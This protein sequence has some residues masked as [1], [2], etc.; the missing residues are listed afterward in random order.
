MG[1]PLDAHAGGSDAFVVELDGSGALQWSTFL[2][3]SS[4]D[5]G[6]G[7]AVDTTGHVYVAGY[8]YG[9]W[10]APATPHVGISDAFAA[11]LDA[12]GALAWNTF[13]GSSAIETGRAVALDGSGDVYVAGDSTAAWGSPVN[14]YAGSQDAFAVRLTPVEGP[15]PGVTGWRLGAVAGLL[16]LSAWWALHGARRLA[17]P[18]P[19]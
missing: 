6:Y 9:T 7:I 12:S 3:S 19:G 4:S 11:E 16:M 18:R 2:G 14:G 15:V 5:E 8:S 17:H 13:M 1:T 10:G